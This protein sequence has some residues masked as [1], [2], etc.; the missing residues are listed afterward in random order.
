MKPLRPAQVRVAAREAVSATGKIK[1][2]DLARLRSLGE[3]LPLLH[4]TSLSTRLAVELKGSIGEGPNHEPFE[5][6]EPFEFLQNSEIFPRRFT[7]FRKFSK[8][9]K[10]SAKFRHNLIKI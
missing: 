6:F 1:D 8:F 5:P 4:P 10:L 9:S 7:N 2:K 3:W